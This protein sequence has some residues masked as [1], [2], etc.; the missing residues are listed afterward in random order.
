MA[1]AGLAAVLDL[2]APSALGFS[3]G[4]LSLLPHVGVVLGATPLLLLA[5][6]GEPGNIAVAV[7]VLI[8][9]LQITDSLVIRAFV[10]RRSLHI[11]VLAPWVVA[12]LGYAVY[13]IGAAAYGLAVAVFA[14]AVP[15]GPRQPTPAQESAETLT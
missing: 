14:L 5:V 3:V 1:V 12:L 9:A 2:P 6:G 7:V 15:D 11:G 13:G 4:V 10:S 8:L